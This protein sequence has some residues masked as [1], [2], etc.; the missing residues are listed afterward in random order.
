MNSFTQHVDAPVEA[1]LIK[2]EV[3][4]EALQSDSIEKPD[5]R[6]RGRWTPSVL[7][8]RPIDGRHSNCHM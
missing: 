1:E 2:A 8:Y 5:R 4:A 7:K 6:R 3:L